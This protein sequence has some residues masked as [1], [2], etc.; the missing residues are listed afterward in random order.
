MLFKASKEIGTPKRKVKMLETHNDLSLAT[1][2]DSLIGLAE[3]AL[4]QRRDVADRDYPNAFYE[5]ILGIEE[6]RSYYGSDEKMKDHGLTKN[7]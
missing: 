4:S 5:K 3:Q 1:L 6:E 2:S 7:E